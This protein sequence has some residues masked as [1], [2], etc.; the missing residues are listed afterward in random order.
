LS[1]LLLLSLSLSS[2]LPLSLLVSSRHPERSEGSLYLSLPLLLQLSL[3]VSSRHPERSEGPLYFVVAF[4]P[5][6]KHEQQGAIA[7]GV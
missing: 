7:P 4:Q 6:K 1:L 5:L 2:L 3:L